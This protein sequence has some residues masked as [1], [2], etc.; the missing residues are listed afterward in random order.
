MELVTERKG[1]NPSPDQ[2]CDMGQ[3]GLRNEVTEDWGEPV[4]S[5][6]GYFKT[7]KML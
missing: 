5:Y 3:K 4:P 6:P 7:Y 1:T 2:H